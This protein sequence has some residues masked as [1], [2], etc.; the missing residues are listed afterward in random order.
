MLAEEAAA[1]AA[2]GVPAPPATTFAHWLA[3]LQRAWAAPSSIA[4]EEQARGD[5]GTA[6]RLGI[7]YYERGC[8]AL[9]EHL[10]ETEWEGV[11]LTEAQV[12]E[13]L[14]WCRRTWGRGS[15]HPWTPQ[16][17]STWTAFELGAR[18]VDMRPLL[19]AYV[20][21]FPAPADVLAQE[22]A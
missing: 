3:R 22:A 20:R 1:A 12:E 14:A 19:E 10:R 11:R 9:R 13:V 17:P 21:L 2:R 6:R 4:D 15:C 5:L 7:I 18:A 16:E 8:A